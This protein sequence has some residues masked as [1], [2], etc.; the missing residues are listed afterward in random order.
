MHKEKE[1][2]GN[3]EERLHSL[4]LELNRVKSLYESLNM[5]IEEDPEV[6]RLKNKLAKAEHEFTDQLNI[7]ANNRIQKENVIEVHVGN[8]Q[9]EYMIHA[10]YMITSG[11]DFRKKMRVILDYDPRGYSLSI[12]YQ[13]TEV[14][15]L[16]SGKKEDQVIS[17]DSLT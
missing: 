16:Q 15:A 9:F 3:I 2:T 5:Q 11:F 13:T 10:L 6:S 8:P 17:Q 7:I 14:E 4:E 12:K 1:N